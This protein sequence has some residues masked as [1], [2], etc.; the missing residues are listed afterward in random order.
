[1]RSAESHLSAVRQAS[2]AGS[3]SEVQACQWDHDGETESAASRLDC[4][5]QV[6]IHVR[7][8]A[9]SLDFSYSLNSFSLGLLFCSEYCDY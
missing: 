9:F 8:Q 1:M 3:D 5:I 7:A 6:V 4:C 2:Q